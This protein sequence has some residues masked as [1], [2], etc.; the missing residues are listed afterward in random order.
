M[1]K[2]AAEY[3]KTASEEAGHECDVRSDYSGRCMYGRETYAVVV[4]SFA[5]MFDDV[6][7]HIR[8]TVDAH[9]DSG[10]VNVPEIG[11]L[12]QDNMGR[13]SVVIY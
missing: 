12:R 5:Q 2:E 6:I 11:L 8:S 1:T 7:E 10:E 13:D 4:D 9:D 3:I